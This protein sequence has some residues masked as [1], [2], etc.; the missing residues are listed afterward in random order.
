[1]IQKCFIDYD[2]FSEKLMV[3]VLCEV[4]MLKELSICNV[5]DAIS[6]TTDSNIWILGL[7]LSFTSSTTRPRFKLNMRARKMQEN[8]TYARPWTRI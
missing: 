6:A 4:D 7:D 1:M 5:D 8:D 3:L 2:M